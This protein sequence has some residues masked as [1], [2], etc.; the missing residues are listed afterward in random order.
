MKTA[1]THRPT[2]R[3]LLLFLI[4]LLVLAVPLLQPPL[5]RW[6]HARA[7]DRLYVRNN[8]AEPLTKIRILF[9]GYGGGVDA[10]YP[11]HEII[12]RG[13]PSN[14]AR[15]QHFEPTWGNGNSG[16][17]LKIEGITDSG[18]RIGRTEMF[19]FSEA[20]EPHRD[21]GLGAR[22]YV[23]VQSDGTLDVRPN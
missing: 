16:R 22:F 20:E 9:Y 19:D 2:F 5:I 15:W 6:R 3:Q 13:V 18:K 12:F 21:W 14:S 11:N 17:Y 4:P 23:S 10:E 7:Q 8:L 1:Q